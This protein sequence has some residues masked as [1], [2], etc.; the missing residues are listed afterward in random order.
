ME[1]GSDPAKTAADKVADDVLQ[2]VEIAVDGSG[3]SLTDQH[4][5][6]K[7]NIT[8]DSARAQA[9]H[10]AIEGKVREGGA[11]AGLVYNGVI[12][13][14]A[15]RQAILRTD[16]TVR[17]AEWAEKRAGR[18]ANSAAED[19]ANMAK[20]TAE[21]TQPRGDE[22][23]DVMRKTAESMTETAQPTKDNVGEAPTKVRCKATVQMAQICFE[24][25]V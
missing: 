12:S 13:V 19:P 10:A 15:T 20:L 14:G 24:K 11:K 4:R 3:C 21:L 17:R 18:R 1:Q 7:L 5:G 25:V 16:E 22:V 2:K 23:D 8:V 6:E 9:R